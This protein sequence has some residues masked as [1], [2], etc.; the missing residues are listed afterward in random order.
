MADRHYWVGRHHLV[1]QGFRVGRHHPVGRHHLV[2]RGYQVGQ[3][4]RA[5]H[6]RPVDRDRWVARCSAD[7]LLHQPVSAP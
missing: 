2:D 3:S 6:P 7:D 5:G 4:Y 1:D